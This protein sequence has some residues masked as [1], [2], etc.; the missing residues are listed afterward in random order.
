M[1][2]VRLRCK[3]VGSYFQTNFLAEAKNGGLEIRSLSEWCAV[4]DYCEQCPGILSDFYQESYSENAKPAQKCWLL[5]GGMVTPRLGALTG[6]EPLQTTQT[7]LRS[8]VW[9]PELVMFAEQW[10]VPEVV[11]VSVFFGAL[12]EGEFSFSDAVGLFSWRDG[13]AL[14]TAHRQTDIDGGLVVEQRAH[15]PDSGV[16]WLLRAT[17]DLY[18]VDRLLQAQGLEWLKKIAT[19]Y[20]NHMLCTWIVEEGGRVTISPTPFLHDGLFVD[21]ILKLLNMMTDLW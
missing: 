5:G 19:P 13:N 17:R 2:D 20:D 3:S 14:S 9:E 15:L 12:L 4:V 21:T 11:T 10:F 8:P 18:P 1:M 6:D 16:L 7:V